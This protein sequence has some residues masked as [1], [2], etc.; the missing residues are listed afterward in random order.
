MDEA[1]FKIL[2]EQTSKLLLAYLLRVT[3]ENAL[4][5]D[6]FQESYVKLLQSELREPTDA[7]LKSYL[8]TTATNLIRDHWRRA[9]KDVRWESEGS[10]DISTIGHEEPAHLGHDFEKAFE[11][12]SPQQRSLLWLA[13]VEG[14]EHKEIAGMLG[15][16]E[17]SIKV[18]LY[19]ARHK[20]KSVLTTMGIGKGGE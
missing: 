16:R 10:G 8:F 15:L 5:D 13:Y 18:L 20:L 3:G 6:V 9:K 14:Y 1:R 17:K 11:G 19:R 2:Y 4:A 12:L 7:K